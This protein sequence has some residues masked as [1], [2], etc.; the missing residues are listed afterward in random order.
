MLQLLIDI[1]ISKIFLIQSNDSLEFY[2]NMIHQQEKMKKLDE[3]YKVLA[4]DNFDYKL[5]LG[6]I[7]LLII[8]VVAIVI[9]MYSKSKKK[10]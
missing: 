2:N 8:M 1:I 7:V 10:K 3:E 5:K 6:L 9:V 4:E